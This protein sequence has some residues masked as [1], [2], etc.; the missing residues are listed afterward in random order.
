M[1]FLLLISYKET[2]SNLNTNPLLGYNSS[3]LVE[4]EKTTKWSQ[5]LQLEDPTSSLFPHE[6]SNREKTE[7][8]KSGIKNV[9]ASTQM[10]SVLTDD[11]FQKQAENVFKRFSYAN[12]KGSTALKRVDYSESISKT[13]FIKS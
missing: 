9:V 10:S 12:Q 13:P 5:R 4:S 8:L 3:C 11:I 6:T 1:L 2:V 7:A